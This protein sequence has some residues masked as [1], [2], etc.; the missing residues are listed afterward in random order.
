MRR[1]QDILQSFDGLGIDHTLG[2]E[3]IPKEDEIMRFVT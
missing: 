1:I 3:N 2:V